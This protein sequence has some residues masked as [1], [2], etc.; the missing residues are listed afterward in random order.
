MTP[1][2]HHRVADLRSA[3][4]LRLY[5]LHSGWLTGEKREEAVRHIAAMRVDLYTL[6]SREGVHPAAEIIPLD[7]P[8]ARA[9]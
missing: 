2:L 5:M 9:V 6:L 1:E 4:N 8:I 3:L 7:P